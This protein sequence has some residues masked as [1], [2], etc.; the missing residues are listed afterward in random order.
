[1][2]WLTPS[3]TALAPQLVA[4]W[5]R[6]P[7]APS[8]AGG[9]KKFAP[10]ALCQQPLCRIDRVV[11]L[12]KR[13]GGRLSPIVYGAS[14]ARGI[15]HKYSERRRRGFFTTPCAA[16]GGEASPPRDKPRSARCRGMRQHRITDSTFRWESGGW[17]DMARMRILGDEY[18]INMFFDIFLRFVWYFKFYSLPLE[19]DI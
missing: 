17:R 9:C 13:R 5:M 15:R 12:Q 7:L 3:A 10:P 14:P 8:F 18:G 1:M 2:R 16:G 6:T 4:D 19:I 11:R